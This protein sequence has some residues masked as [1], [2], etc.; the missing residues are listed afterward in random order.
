M[1]PETLLQAALYLL[2]AR[3]VTGQFLAV[4][5]GQHL[6]WETPDMMIGED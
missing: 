2:E 3:S 6:R 5:S 1:T 4:D